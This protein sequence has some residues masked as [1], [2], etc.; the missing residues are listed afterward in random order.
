MKENSLSAIF[1]NKISHIG[2]H[3]IVVDVTN[4]PL[5]VRQL[6]FV[7]SAWNSPTIRYYPNPSFQMF[8]AQRPTEQLCHYSISNAADSQAVILACVS[9]TARGWQVTAHG[10]LS[11]GNANNYEPIKATIASQA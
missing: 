3:N 9:R 5:D 1:N 6:Y 10:R 7:L 2:H 11:A 4:L 8:D